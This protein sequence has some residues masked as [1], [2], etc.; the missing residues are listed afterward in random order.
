MVALTQQLGYASW[1]PR[2]PSAVGLTPTRCCAADDDHYKN[3]Y[4][5]N[6]VGGLM[7]GAGMALSGSCPGTVFA[8]VGA[9]CAA[10]CS[11][12]ALLLGNALPA[13]AGSV[14]G[15]VVYIGLVRPAVRARMAS[16]AARAEKRRVERIARDGG[17]DKKKEA[18]ERAPPPRPINLAVYDLFRT[19]PF[20]TRLAVGALMAGVVAALH[21]RPEL[22]DQSTL[23]VVPPVVGGLLIGAAQL[24]TILV[25][26][27]LMGTSTSFEEVAA[28]ILATLSSAASVVTGA[29]SAWSW[30]SLSWKNVQYVVGMIVGARAVATYFPSAAAA[31]SSG[32][33]SMATSA[34]PAAMVRVAAGG[35]LL[36][37][38]SRI[39]GGCTSGHG[40][41]GMSLLS[42]SSIVTVASMFAGAVGVTRLL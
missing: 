18:A 21:K 20:A 26:R 40:I 13:L 14:A 9:G 22:L 34:S 41:S 2:S 15:G 17:V 3:S 36:T 23:G 11:A 33:A 25:R 7:L 16:L 29:K 30:S 1:S 31:A 10:G 8:Q 38:G 19:N 5:G 24:L 39:A 6:V 42:V 4:D 28:G 37:V 32:I 12:S 35:I 27:Q